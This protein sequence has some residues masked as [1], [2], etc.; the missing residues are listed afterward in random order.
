MTIHGIGPKVARELYD[1][2]E[3][4]SLEDV[5]TA[6]PAFRMEVKYWGE[7]QSR[8]VSDRRQTLSEHELTSSD[9]FDPPSVTG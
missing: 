8:S 7:I 2:F 6:K 9:A 4:R 3:C 5:Y 1:R